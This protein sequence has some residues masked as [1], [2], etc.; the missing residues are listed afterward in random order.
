M[1]Q[2]NLDSAV[3]RLAAAADYRDRFA[4]VFGRPVNAVDLVRAIASYERSQIAFGSPFDRFAAGDSAAIPLAARRGWQLFNGQARCFKCHALTDTTRKPTTFT[5]N[6]FHN[7]GVGIIRH[8]VVALARKAEQEVARGDTAA[9]DS[10]AIITP[11][12][13]IGRYL[14]T[15]KQSDIAAF[16]TPDLRNVLVTGPYFHD[17]SMATL[18]D[19]MDHYNKGDGI[20]DPFLDQDI[21]PLALSERDI[22][23]VVAM[24]ASLTS[25]PYAAI[26]RAPTVARRYRR[27]LATSAETLA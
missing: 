17:G 20:K 18:W 1:G 24:L 27:C 12:S 25:A 6:D 13:A 9:I 5:D 4:R 2:P 11:M 3:A 10:S 21:Q 8:N 23:D 26:R 22:D 7:I 15:R 16:K 14:V 19:V